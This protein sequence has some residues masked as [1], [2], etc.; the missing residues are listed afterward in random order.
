MSFVSLIGM[1]NVWKLFNSLGHLI[2][3]HVNNNDPIIYGRCHIVSKSQS[4]LGKFIG[5][6][7]FSARLWYGILKMILGN[8]IV[9][10]NDL[11][12]IIF[13]DYLRNGFQG[14]TCHF[15]FS[16][17]VFW[18][19]I[20]KGDFGIKT[21]NLLALGLASV[22]SLDSFSYFSSKSSRSLPQLCLYSHLLTCCGWLQGVT[23]RK[24]WLRCSLAHMYLHQSL[25]LG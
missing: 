24:D 22:Y 2:M 17:E 6:L 13:L 20:R 7:T 9:L 25:E 11:T 16:E 14:T 18:D 21:C 12:C 4:Q 1:Q 3:P 15:M 5:S 19:F 23:R 8:L 10:Y